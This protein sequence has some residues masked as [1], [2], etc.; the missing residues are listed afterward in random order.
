MN[1]LLLA[2]EKKKSETKTKKISRL[3]F[4]KHRPQSEHFRLVF[5]LEA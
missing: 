4:T 1:F 5:L 2:W 3:L